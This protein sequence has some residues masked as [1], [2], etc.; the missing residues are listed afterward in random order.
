MQSAFAQRLALSKY[1]LRS[2][3]VNTDEEITFGRQMTRCRPH[4]QDAL[5]PGIE[6]GS[7][8]TKV[9]ACPAIQI[10]VFQAYVLMALRVST[11]GSFHFRM[12]LDPLFLHPFR[13]PL[14]ITETEF[15]QRTLRQPYHVSNGLEIMETL[16]VQG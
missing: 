8:G 1:S 7:L 15:M 13:P 9:Q 3:I 10:V 16:F 11:P 6:S 4:N 12:F 14:L 2:V 5:V